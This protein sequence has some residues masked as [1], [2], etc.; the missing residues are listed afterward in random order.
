MKPAHLNNK[1]SNRI[2]LITSDY[3]NRD[4]NTASVSV[5][6]ILPDSLESRRIEFLDYVNAA[7]VNI[8]S[9]AK[10]YGWG[11]LTKKEFMDRVIIFDDK[12]EFNLTLLKLAEADPTKHLP[13]TYCAALEKRTLISVTPEYFSEVY[14]EGNE[15]RSFEKLLTHEIAH[16]LH[17]RIL[18]GDEKAMGPIW[19]YEGFAIYAAD[20]FSISDIILC[21]EEMIK[22]MK[23]PERGSYVN[24]NYIFRYFVNKVPLKELILKAKEENFNDELIIMLN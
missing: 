4:Q 1:N 7:R 21:K 6:L 24:Y 16:R 5:P 19:F 3:K 15:D 18:N 11:V 22:I 13:D 20:Q 2:N 14:P 9:F 12:N 8:I 23:D 17:I 10:E